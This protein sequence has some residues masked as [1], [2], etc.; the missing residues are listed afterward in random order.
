M[1]CVSYRYGPVEGCY[2][3]VPQWTTD[4]CNLLL[5]TIIIIIIRRKRRRRR[6]IIIIIIIIIIT[7]RSRI[8]LQ[9]LSGSQLVNSPHFM[10]PESSLPPSQ[11]PVTCPYS[12]PDQTCPC[13]LHPP[14]LRSILILSSHLLLGILSGLVPSGL[15]TKTLYAP[16]LSSSYL[17]LMLL[18]GFL[19]PSFLSK[20]LP[21]L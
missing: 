1:D 7:P 16:L 11:V 3:K 2:E 15:P 21:A 17:S 5:I 19:S 14:S 12:E 4:C 6:R 8:L 20:R 18:L 13:P 10:E 9:K